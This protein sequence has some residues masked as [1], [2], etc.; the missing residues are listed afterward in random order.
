MDKKYLTKESF[1]DFKKELDELK[2]KKRIE[3]AERIMHA[4]EYGDLSENS[5]YTSAREEQSVIE[6]RIFELEQLLKNAAI[7][8]KKITGDK[9]KVGSTITIRK[10]DKSSKKSSS[11]EVKYT[12][13]GS[14]EARPEEGRISDESP[15]S[16]AFLSHKKG[17]LVEISAP[18]G[19]VVYEIIKVE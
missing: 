6:S 19:V 4:K 5:E 18:S 2:T 3:V 13:V 8:D 7:I 11:P 17:D 1:E 16:K 9:I 10:I 15:F 14:Y 12:I